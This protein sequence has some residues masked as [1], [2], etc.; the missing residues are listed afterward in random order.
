MKHLGSRRLETERLILR[1]F[2]LDDA[3]AMYDNWAKDP[4][5][6]RYLSWRPHEDVNVSRELLR[7]WVNSY[8]FPE[9]YNWA[10]EVKEGSVLIGSIGV[11]E[12]K[13]SIR[14]VSIGYCIGQAW[15]H[16]GYVSE[17]LKR[18]LAFFFDQVGVNRIQACH[19]A[20]NIHSGQ[21]MEKCG[22]CYEGLMRQSI[23]KPD[24]LADGRYYAILEEDYRKM[25][26]G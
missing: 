6:T 17:A 3:Q 16:Q 10:I 19:E 11:A 15:W 14:M 21:V 5:V 26:G 13:D 4:Q 1:P 8:A 18:L 20:A 22:M 12:P 23:A 2:R 7:I 9:F 25:I 24:G